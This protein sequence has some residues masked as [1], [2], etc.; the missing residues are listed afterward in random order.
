M[1]ETDADQPQHR[2]ANASPRRWRAPACAR[3]ATRRR[4]S[5]PAASASTARAGQPRLQRRPGR[6]RPRRRR[7]AQGARAHAAVPVPQAAR[8]GD[9]GARSRRAADDLRRSAQ[10]PAARGRGRPARHQHRGPAAADQRRRPG[11]GARTAGDR[12]APP[13]P[14]A[15][16]WRGRPGGARRAARGRDDRRHPLRRHRGAARAHAGL[17]TSG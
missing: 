6:R 14:R 8:A 3:A 10:G 1:T 4:G 7:A 13:L 12:L 5:P 16:P 2:E 9:D 15:R 17:A 11:A